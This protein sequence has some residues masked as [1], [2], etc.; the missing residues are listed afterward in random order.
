MERPITQSLSFSVRKSGAALD[1]LKQ[2][3]S[4]GDH[5]G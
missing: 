3:L 1:F 2:H 4:G 5:V